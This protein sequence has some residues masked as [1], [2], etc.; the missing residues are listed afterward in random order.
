[1]GWQMKKSK[2]HL[3]CA[4]ATVVLIAAC[5]T[6][7]SL[8]ADLPSKSAGV[9]ISMAVGGW[10]FSPTLFAGGVYNSN[11]NQSNTG[12]VSS[13][14]E[15]IVPGF[16]ANLDNGI[17]QTSLYGIADLQNYTAAGVNR[18]T[19]VDAKAGVTQTYLAQRDLTF[20]FNGDFTRQSDV[21]GAGAF[22]PTNTPLTPTSSAPVAPTTV[23]PQVNPIRYNQYTGALAVKK[24]FGRAFVALSGS[25]IRTNFDS[26][27]VPTTSRD[28][29]VYTVAQRTGFNLTPQLYVF[30]DPSVSWQRYTDSTR[31][32]NGYRVTTGLGTIAPGLWQGEVYGGYQAQ[33]NDIVGTYSSGVYGFRVGYSPTRMWDLRASLDEALGAS[34]IA[35]GNTGVV[36][37]TGVAGRVTTALLGVG[38]RGLP[39]GWSTNARLGYVRS[40]FVG[41]SRRDNA[42]LMG[43]NVGYEI[44]RNLGLM[45]D[46]Q[47][48]SVDSNITGQSFNQQMVSLG[49]SYKY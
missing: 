38:Y 8:A 47:Y 24:D 2:A 19:T 25:A 17:H 20:T 23:A 44:W 36:G 49:V 1:M 37:N 48:K 41:S 21:F 18:K 42:W 34:T 26:S 15:R 30:V 10:L 31:N 4:S 35:M 16:T 27:P 29:T 22:A 9:P 28:G 33:K 12:K 46:Y 7:P 3:L 40:D 14:G 11:V 45:L 6:S 13:W 5:Y 39:Q 43:A 32:S